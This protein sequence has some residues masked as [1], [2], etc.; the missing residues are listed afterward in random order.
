MLK[1]ICKKTTLVILP[2]A[3]LLT[4][5]SCYTMQVGRTDG[6]G[7]KGVHYVPKT[8]QYTNLLI[9]MHGLG[10]TA[11]GWASMMPSLKLEDTKIVLPTAKSRPIA[12]NDN[13]PMPGKRLR[14]H[15]QVAANN[16]GM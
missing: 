9:F 14:C 13:M 4:H 11:D 12:L 15:T 16:T 1:S 10:D 5:T 7:G 2:F 6:A 8:G 3:F